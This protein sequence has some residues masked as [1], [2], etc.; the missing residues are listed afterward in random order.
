LCLGCGKSS[1][2]DPVNF[3]GVKIDLI[4][5]TGDI[6]TKYIIVKIIVV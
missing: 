4:K 1:Q 2:Y 6:T 5:P 3:L